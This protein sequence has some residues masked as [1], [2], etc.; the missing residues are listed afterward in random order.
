[1]NV[2]RYTTDFLV[3]GSGI[4]GLEFAIEA[5]KIGNVIVI[6]KGEVTNGSTSLA[7]GGIAAVLPGTDDT[8]EAHIKDT[9]D[10]GAGLSKP[11]IVEKIVRYAP[12]VINK[13]K[14]LGVDFS[15]KGENC[16]DPDRTRE[17]GHS[18]N[19]VIHVADY[20]GRAIMS[21]LIENA[22]RKGRI[23]IWENHMAI[24]LLT[25]HHIPKYSMKPW[26]D[27]VCF[28]A[29]VL[30]VKEEIVHTVLS[31][32]T[33]LATGGAGKLYLHTTNDWT[34]S[35]D[36]IAMA[37]RAGARVANLEFMQFH[38]TVLCDSSTEGERAFLISEAV[39]GEGAILLNSKKER[40]MPKYH[41]MA[42]LAPRDIVARSIDMEL[43]ATGDPCV[44]LDIRHRGKSFLKKRFPL[45]YETLLARGF[46]LSENLIPVVPAA[47]YLCGGVVVDE[48][49]KTDI[50][51]LFAIGEVAHTGMHGANRLASN[52]LLEA[53]AMADFC[54]QDIAKHF[55]PNKDFPEIPDWDDSGTFDRKEW[56]IVRHNYQ[57]LRALMWDYMGITRS[58]SRLEKALERVRSMWLEVDDF[59]R[60][61]PVKLKI[62]EL[63][64]MLYVAELMIRSALLRRESR[65][66]HYLVDYPQPS[67][68]YTQ[69]TVLRAPGV[70]K[71]I[72]LEK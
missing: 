5:S 12:N 14:R 72:H 1:M 59:Y 10:T 43:K 61:N 36:G 19:R 56:V 3:I 44:F 13:L 18:K 66:L 50:K 67:S 6:S 40:F 7:Q 17:G 46:D 62:I 22:R 38:P 16:D 70:Y 20:T 52:S 47:H 57:M 11:H 23:R 4:A 34:A 28:G 24:D 29:Y 48:S 27:I 39:R 26:E 21:A 9:L 42:E 32:Y 60:K 49:G 53:F 68:T 8:F 65:G 45:I 63:R 30:D 2:K 31:N 37:Y 33:I 51:N 55:S 58:I 69:D 54:I 41:P 35:G 64:N 15:K 25:Q 71:E